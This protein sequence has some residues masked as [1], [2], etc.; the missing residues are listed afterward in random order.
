MA[1]G[2]AIFDD[3]F[4]QLAAQTLEESAHTGEMLAQT[5]AER[6]GAIG[7]ETDGVVV[8]HL[9]VAEA[10]GT[11]AAGDFFH[12]VVMHP[13]VAEIP[14]SAVAHLQGSAVAVE[15]VGGLGPGGGARVDRPRTRTRCRG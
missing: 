8:I 4:G 2:R 11:Q 1:A 12:E 9:E 13:R 6:F 7:A 15:L 3:K 14:E 5:F 10:V